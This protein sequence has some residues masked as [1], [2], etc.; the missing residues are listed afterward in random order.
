MV[1]SINNQI[2]QYCKRTRND[3]TPKFKKSLVNH[4][5][6]KERDSSISMIRVFH[7][8]SKKSE[9]ENFDLHHSR[10]TRFPLNLSTTL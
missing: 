3:P 2:P 9:I 1:K 6:L 4:I 5:F 10:G 7:K 8:G